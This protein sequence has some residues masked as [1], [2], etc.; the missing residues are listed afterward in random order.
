MKDSG[1]FDTPK[2]P[3][4]MKKA[5]DIKK[6]SVNA[7]GK[8]WSYG[9]PSDA[10]YSRKASGGGTEGGVNRKPANGR[11]SSIFGGKGGLEP[12]GQASGHK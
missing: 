8:P 12:G 4:D 6:D 7:S 9:R 1:L 2:R 5:G 3:N 11:P 10:S